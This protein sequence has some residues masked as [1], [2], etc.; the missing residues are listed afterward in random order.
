MLSASGRGHHPALLLLCPMYGVLSGGVGAMAGGPYTE[1]GRE[2]RM[3]A[4]RKKK[5][6]AYANEWERVKAM[7]DALPVSDEVPAQF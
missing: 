5:R 3:V 4:K 2:A 7:L 6:H 1:R